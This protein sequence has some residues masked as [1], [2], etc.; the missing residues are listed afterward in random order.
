MLRMSYGDHFLSVTCLSI[1]ASN[2]PLTLSNNNSSKA[3]NEICP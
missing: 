3:I 1:H 2:R